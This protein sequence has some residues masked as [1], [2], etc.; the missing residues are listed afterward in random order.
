[1]NFCNFCKEVIE[2]SIKLGRMINF[3]K[4]LYVLHIFLIF[5][6]ILII[7]A[8]YFLLLIIQKLILLSGI[9]SK[10]FVHYLIFILFC[11]NYLYIIIKIIIIWGQIGFDQKSNSYLFCYLVFLLAFEIF[12]IYTIFQVYKLSKYEYKIKLGYI[13]DENNNNRGN[14]NNQDNNNDNEQLPLINDN[15]IY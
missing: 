14:G 8:D 12:C 2:P 3:L 11:L 7:K 6:D 13:I 1:M 5:I 4:I 10:Y 15:R 9:S